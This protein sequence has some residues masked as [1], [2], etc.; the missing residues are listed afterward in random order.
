MPDICMCRGET[1]PIKETCYRYLAVPSKP[2]Q[3]Y[4][5]KIPFDIEN[6][7]CDYYIEIT[8][9]IEEGKTIIKQKI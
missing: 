7:F 8:I 3:S 1:C 2:L 5:S 9:K 6:D 4:Y